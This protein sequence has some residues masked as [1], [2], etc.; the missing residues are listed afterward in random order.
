LKTGWLKQN[1]NVETFSQLPFIR[2][3]GL[4]WSTVWT[5]TPVKQNS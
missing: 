2:E 1:N 3:A 5:N 4:T